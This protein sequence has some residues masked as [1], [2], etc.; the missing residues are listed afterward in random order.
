MPKT[1]SNT[2]FRILLFNV[3]IHRLSVCLEARPHRLLSHKYLRRQID[4][5]VAITRREPV[6]PVP[7]LLGQCL[8]VGKRS[9]L[10]S[11]LLCFCPLLSEL[12]LSDL[13]IVD[14]AQ[15]LS[16]G[17]VPLSV[18]DNETL[19]SRGSSSGILLLAQLR[20]LRGWDKTSGCR[21]PES[22]LF[23]RSHTEQ[24]M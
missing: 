8:E 12:D 9:S 24:I 22:R 15:V 6:H 20:E 17:R 3:E 19:N 18:K 5:L 7:D 1:P 10:G 11:D 23:S 21:C 4:Y 16:D 2:A 14:S 13:R